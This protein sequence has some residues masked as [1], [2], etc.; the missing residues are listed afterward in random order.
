MTC[1]VSVILY[2]TISDFPEEVTWLSAEEKDFVKARLHAEVGQSRRNDP[3]TVHSVLQV[4]K[5][6]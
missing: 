5:D 3:L 4:F 1:V 6:C 2:F